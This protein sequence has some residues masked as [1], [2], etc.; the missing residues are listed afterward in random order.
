MPG[1]SS[2]RSPARDRL[3]AVEA[4]WTRHGSL[5]DAG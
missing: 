3:A 2:L 5:I 4:E 1:L